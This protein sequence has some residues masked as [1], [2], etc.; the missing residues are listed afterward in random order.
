MVDPIY[1]PHPLIAA[2]SIRN[3]LISDGVELTKEQE[4]FIKD[5]IG[6]SAVLS[7][8]LQKLA[9]EAGVELWAM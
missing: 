5:V 9:A 3:K 8:H 4:E 6:N 1:D 7:R 2:L